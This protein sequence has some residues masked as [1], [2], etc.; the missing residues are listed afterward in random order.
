MDR[1]RARR[2]Q[3]NGMIKGMETGRMVT[4]QETRGENGLCGE[5]VSSSETLK[6]SGNEAS[7]DLFK[8]LSF[9]SQWMTTNF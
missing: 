7:Q 9:N 5:A 2:G 1:Q 8:D 3:V 4:L 6:T